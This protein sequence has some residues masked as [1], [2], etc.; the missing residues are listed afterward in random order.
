MVAD[1]LGVDLK[2]GVPIEITSLD[3]KSTA[4][5][6]RLNF[7][8][9]EIAIHDLPVAISEKDTMPFLLGCLGVLDS[10]S[11]SLSH[12]DGSTCLEV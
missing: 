8:F 9:G 10:A 6:H 11:V 4:Y 5:I 1:E 12:A 3:G 2:S 7:T